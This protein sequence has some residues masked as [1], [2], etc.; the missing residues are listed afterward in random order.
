MA[1]IICFLTEGR[2]TE[3]YASSIHNSHQYS[4][5]L[6][7]MKRWKMHTDAVF[8]KRLIDFDQEGVK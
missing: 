4:L 1:C 7:V 5:L 8:H 3:V 6:L 2:K